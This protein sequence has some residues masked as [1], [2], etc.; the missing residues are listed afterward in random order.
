[1]LNDYV[2]DELR[3]VERSISNAMTRTMRIAEKKVKAL[4]QEYFI[5]NY[6][7]GYKP[8]S[9]IRTYQLKKA[10]SQYST[11]TSDISPTFSF[12]FGPEFDEG[13]MNHSTHSARITIKVKGKRKTITKSRKITSSKSKPNETLILENALAG[14]HPGV[15]TAGTKAPIFTASQTGVL[16]DEIEKFLDELEVIF[17]N[18]LRKYL[19]LE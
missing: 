4:G 7:Q 10:F 16:A 5:R 19:T 1:M 15:G 3:F 8:I 6:Y 12:E 13:A 2:D 11:I 14:I 9:Y 17:E 18:E